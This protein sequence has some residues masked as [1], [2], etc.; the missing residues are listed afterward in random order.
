MDRLHVVIKGPGLNVA[1]PSSTYAFHNL[2]D[3][4]P[5]KLTGL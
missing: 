2:N 3:R 1:L 5:E 4:S